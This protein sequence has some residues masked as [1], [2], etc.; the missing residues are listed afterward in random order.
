MPAPC[1][2]LMAA[3][4]EDGGQVAA[5]WRQR[6]SWVRSLPTFT[7]ICE[8]HLGGDPVGLGEVA[9]ATGQDDL[10]EA[11]P[12]GLDP[13]LQPGRDQEH[14]LERAGAVAG[15]EPVG[16]P[17]RHHAAFGEDDDLVAVALGGQEVMGGEDRK[18]TRLN[19]S[20]VRISYAAFCLKKKKIVLIKRPQAAPSGAA[21]M[22]LG[23]VPAAIGKAVFFFFCW[24]GGRRDLHS[25]PTRRSSD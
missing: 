1:R 13:L 20:H 18:S 3:N 7:V 5:R 2:R 22:A 4:G 25:F 12:S 24:C 15:Q 10:A 23:L 19:S 11:R 14:A 9:P 21:E 17:F 16:R 6:A 8:G